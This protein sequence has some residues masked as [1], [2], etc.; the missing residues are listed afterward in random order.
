MGNPSTRSRRTRGEQLSSLEIEEVSA[1]ATPLRADLETSTTSAKGDRALTIW[2]IRIGLVVVILGSWQ[3]TATE[4]WINPLF[5]S[6]PLEIW[7]ALRQTAV[8]TITKQLPTTLIEMILGLLLGATVGFLAGILLSRLELLNTALR[9][10]YVAANSLPRIA[11]APLFIIWFGLGVS[12]KI[13]LSF[14]LV[15]FIVMINTLAGL[16]QVDRDF[17]ILAKSMGITGFRRLRIFLLPAAVPMLAAAM[18]LGIVYSFLG[19]IT[20]ELVGGSKGL[21][22]QLAEQATAF[23]TADFFASLFILAV[24]TTIFTQLMHLLARRM[25]KWHYIEMRGLN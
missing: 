22:V 9:P 1:E 15:V 4:K 5:T 14:T 12:S 25:L 18:E 21:G 23:Q 2:S 3:L 6:S 19:V 7:I 16:T 11:L 20:G 8:A 17:A 10:L 24:I 13:A